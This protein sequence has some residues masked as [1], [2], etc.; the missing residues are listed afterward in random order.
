M[1]GYALHPKADPSYKAST[2]TR[3]SDVPT[4]SIVRLVFCATRERVA[5]VAEALEAGEIPPDDPDER[6]A[7][8]LLF[9]VRHLEQNLLDL[10]HVMVMCRAPLG[11]AAIKLLVAEQRDKE[12]QG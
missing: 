5:E 12:A 4:A 7:P 3:D 9:G 11:P 10:A 2:K 8:F 1:I 6:T